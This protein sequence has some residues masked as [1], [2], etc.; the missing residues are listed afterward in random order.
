MLNC[1][2]T[3]AGPSPCNYIAKMSPPRSSTLWLTIGV[4]WC[5]HYHFTKRLDSH[6]LSLA[7]QIYRLRRDSFLVNLNDDFLV[8]ERTILTK[9]KQNRVILNFA[10][11]FQNKNQESTCF[12]ASCHAWPCG[13]PWWSSAAL[14][15][16]K[17]DWF[18][19]K[20]SVFVTRK[21]L[22]PWEW[23]LEKVT[24][25][26]RSKL[27][28][29]LDSLAAKNGKRARWARWVTRPRLDSKLR[30]VCCIGLSVYD[31][32]APAPIQIGE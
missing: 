24:A 22:N 20:L 1:T 16:V 27:G 15:L 6:H 10:P 14:G 29:S 13:A 3:Q 12:V 32:S 2:S 7:G 25:I 31:F 18:L 28:L 9:Q 5:K 30:A 19:L 4:F 26:V 8:S 11:N 17:H 23:K 21:R